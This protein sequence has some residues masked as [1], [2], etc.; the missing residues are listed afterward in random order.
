MTSPAGPGANVPK[1]AAAYRERAA[2][3]IGGLGYIGSHLSRALL[4]AGARVTVVTRDRGRYEP[5]AAIFERDGVRIIE[6]DVRHHATMRSSIA[7]ADAVFNLSGQSGAIRS[8][9]DPFADLEVN[10]AG[11]LAVLEALRTEAPRAKF[12][13]ASSR[14]V[15]GAPRTLP[16]AEDHPVAPLCPHGAHKAAVE[17]YL[18]MYG[19]LF[20]LRATVLRMTNPYGPGQPAGRNAYGVINFL[21]HRALAGQSLPIYGDGAQLRDY[22]FIGDVVGALVAVGMDA[23][24]DGRIYNVASGAGTSMLD[25]ARQIVN[26]VGDGLIEHQ[27]WPPLA[28]E[29][30]TGDFVADVGRI[31]RE[32]GWTPTTAFADGLRRTVAASARQNVTP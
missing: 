16:V 30:D 27:P 31:G 17:Q 5:L 18:A 20:G 28:H 21:I 32:L 1:S 7:G 6:A 23:R 19:R 29:I 2:V 26:T 8:V 13:F 22:V 24:S 15:Y 12:V 4:D 9:Q 3:V 10:C 25:A 11:N 14:L